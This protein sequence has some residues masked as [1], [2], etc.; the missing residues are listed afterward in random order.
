MHMYNLLTLCIYIYVLL[1]EVRRHPGR[2]KGRYLKLPLVRSHSIVARWVYLNSRLAKRVALH[3]TSIQTTH[4][5]EN[6]VGHNESCRDRRKSAI[7]RQ[8]SNESTRENERKGLTRIKL[9]SLS[10]RRCWS[11]MNERYSIRSYTL[12]GIRWSRRYAYI[13][14]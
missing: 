13:I 9:S 12:E 5:L 4:E 14:G 10:F 7:V 1:F 2:I 8:K 11:Y 6:D 3:L